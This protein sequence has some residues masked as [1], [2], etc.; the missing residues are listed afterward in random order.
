MI[1][2]LAVLQPDKRDIYRDISARVR[3]GMRTLSYERDIQRDIQRDKRDILGFSPC[4]EG[5]TNG[6]SPVGGVPD[7]PTD[8]Q[9]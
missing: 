7:V 1:A 8:G 4:P 6:T 3:E 9:T 2:L 5:G